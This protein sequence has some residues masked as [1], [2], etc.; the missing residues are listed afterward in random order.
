LKV[1]REEENG[2]IKFGDTSKKL[3]VKVTA[4]LHAVFNI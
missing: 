4:D 1:A 2:F 3:G